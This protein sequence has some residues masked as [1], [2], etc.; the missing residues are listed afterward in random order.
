MSAP[1]SV[2]EIT[3]PVGLVRSDKHLDKTK[4]HNASA[5]KA[6]PEPIT[7]PVCAHHQAEHI[8]RSWTD[9]TPYTDGRPSNADNGN[10][11]PCYASIGDEGIPRLLPVQNGSHDLIPAVASDA[12]AWDFPRRLSQQTLPS[13]YSSITTLRLELPES[14]KAILS[15]PP[16]KS[17]IVEEHTQKASSTTSTPLGRSAS[18]IPGLPSS[19]NKLTPTPYSR[20]KSNGATTTSTKMEDRQDDGINDKKGCGRDIATG[21]P[22]QVEGA[23]LG[24]TGNR[25]TSLSGTGRVEKHIGASPVEAETAPNARSRKSSLMMQLFKDTS[26]EQ[27]KGQH[28]KRQAIGSQRDKHG[29]DDGAATSG[30]PYGAKFSKHAVGEAIIEESDDAGREIV[31]LQTYQGKVLKEHTVSEHEQQRQALLPAL[32][33]VSNESRKGDL[34]STWPSHLPHPLLTEVRNRQ[35]GEGIADVDGEEDGSDKEHVSSAIY[36]P[37]KAPS[38]DTLENAFSEGHAGREPTHQEHFLTLSRPTVKSPLIERGEPLQ[39]DH[40]SGPSSSKASDSGVSSASDSEYSYADEETTPKATPATHGANLGSRA[41]RGRR[42]HT[43]PVQAIEL[44]PFK[45]QV[46]GHTVLYKFHKKGV[47][48]PLT[49]EENKFYELIELTHPELLEFLT[50]YVHLF[51]SH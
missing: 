14:A 29:N 10:G 20:A 40:G 50:G 3:S 35:H 32:A 49:N 31:S 24:A 42:P 2:A 21:S 4:Q 19:A 51:Q 16:S 23:H 1:V 44:V 37:H 41:R 11:R 8:S 9:T 47:T 22:T 13:S 7:P 43:V 46:G 30:A 6:K 33:D 5:S 38:P 34:T 25:S 27:K 12:N 28:K 45:H 39:E 15:D 18:Y 36:Y 26:L 17:D 48:K